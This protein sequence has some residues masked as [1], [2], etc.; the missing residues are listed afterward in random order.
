M[1]Q[2]SAGAIYPDLAGKSVI[3]T[4]GGSGIGA[5]IVRAFVRQNSRVGFIDIAEAPSR[6]LVAELGGE[7]ANVRFI[8]ADI[9]DLG[10]LKAAI[11]TISNAHGAADVLINNAAH[12]ERHA[13]QDVT[14][15]MFDERIAVNLRHAFF[16]TQAVLPGMQARGGGVVI[17]FSSMSWMAGMGGMPVY[18]A[19]KSAM[20]GLTRSLARD[21]GQYNIRVNAIAPGWV[22]TERQVTK[23]LTPEGDKRRL[24][25][26]C[27]K[28]WVEPEDIARFAVFLASDDASACTAQHYVVDA[29]WV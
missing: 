11:T 7:T 26:Q 1:A 22:R 23:W 9:R 16:A 10:A 4:G 25:A 13:T 29:G 8:K 14:P 3:V 18:T 15:E 12:D 2:K 27:L 5:A 24:D 28:R 17:N 6:M 20:I 19:S 21:Y